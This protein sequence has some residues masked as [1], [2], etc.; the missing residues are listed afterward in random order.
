MSGGESTYI[1]PPEY[2]LNTAH[3]MKINTMFPAK[4]RDYGSLNGLLIEDYD[5]HS[6]DLLKPLN[7]F[8]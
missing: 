7:Q 8:G 5:N 3:S 4:K 1:Q 6:A 2:S